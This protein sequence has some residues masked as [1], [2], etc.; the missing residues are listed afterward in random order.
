MMC[1]IGGLIDWFCSFCFSFDGKFY[2]GYVGD[3]LVLVLLV[4]DV[5]LMG[6]SFKYYCLCGVFSVGLE[7]LNVLVELCSG[8]W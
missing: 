1:L 7:E 4:N 5:C 3:M 8:V 6:C 2:V